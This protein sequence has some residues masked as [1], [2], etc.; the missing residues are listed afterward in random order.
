MAVEGGGRPM[1]Q[2]IRTVLGRSGTNTGSGAMESVLIEGDPLD[3]PVTAID[4]LLEL[5]AQ[6]RIQP[7]SR[8]G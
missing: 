4:D 8:G 7:L 3:V 2:Q 6:Q 1:H 5:L